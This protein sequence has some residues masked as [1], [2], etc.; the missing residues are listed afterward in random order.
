MSTFLLS[1][2]HR[3]EPYS[4]S[5]KR[6]ERLAASLETVLEH[7][8]DNRFTH[9]AGKDQWSNSLSTITSKAS[10]I[11]AVIFAQ[12]S[13]WEFR[14]ELLSANAVQETASGQGKRSRKPQD[15][16]I[17][18]PAILKTG[19]LDGRKLANPILKEDAEVDSS[20]FKKQPSSAKEFVLK[21][22]DS[23]QPKTS[24]PQK[25]LPLTPTAPAPLYV[26]E[27]RPIVEPQEDLQSTRRP[28]ETGLP[29]Q[30]N[31]M[32]AAR[33]PSEAALPIQGNKRS[34]HET[35]LPPKPGREENPASQRRSVKGHVSQA[36]DHVPHTIKTMGRTFFGGKIETDTKSEPA[37]LRRY[38]RKSSKPEP[39]KKTSNSSCSQEENA[40]HDDLTQLP[41]SDLDDDDHLDSPQ[42]S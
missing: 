13:T 40:M 35:D 18:F 24:S 32:Q 33:R 4:G 15:G 27:P 21:R 19:D 2:P 6:A 34:E 29:R 17:V 5:E 42:V 41:E 20:M 38:Q 31:R 36:I 23:L 8:L 37:K 9:G 30:G 3:K 7:F 11:G 25:Q 12:P 26:S 16:V 28:S 22:K 10:R 39:D 1:E 14:W